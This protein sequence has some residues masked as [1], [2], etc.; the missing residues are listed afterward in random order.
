MRHE[1]TEQGTHRRVKFEEGRS[2]SVPK[3]STSQRQWE[4]NQC[5]FLHIATP[6]G[7]PAGQAAAETSGIC[8]CRSVEE[9][10]NWLHIKMASLKSINNDDFCWSRNLADFPCLACLL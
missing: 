1:A 8:I 9:G 2:K 3:A 7:L 4:L 6:P 10:L 5:M